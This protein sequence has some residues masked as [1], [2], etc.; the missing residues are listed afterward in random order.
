MVPNNYLLEQLMYQ[1][2]Q[3][4]LREAQQARLMHTCLS[5]A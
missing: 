5:E 3:A 1:R 4:L 2:R